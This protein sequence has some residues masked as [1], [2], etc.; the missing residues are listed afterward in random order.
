VCR[1]TSAWHTIQTHSDQSFHEKISYIR[2]SCTLLAS[3]PAHLRTFPFHL[4]A[5]YTLP[6]VFYLPFDFSIIFLL[7]MTSDLSA[8]ASIGFIKPLSY[9]SEFR[10]WLLAATDIFAEQVWLALIEGQEPW[11]SAAT[12][13]ASATVSSSSSP[14]INSKLVDSKQAWDTKATKVHGLLGWMLDGNHR[15]MYSTERDPA[16]V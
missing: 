16:T 12:E 1:L 4:T 14:P 5:S 7:T 9:H 15:K 6:P 2:T 13:S 8:L 10:K 11:P 3:H